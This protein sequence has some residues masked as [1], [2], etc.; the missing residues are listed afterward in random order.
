MDIPPDLQP[1]TPHLLTSAHSTFFFSLI[2]VLFWFRRDVDLDRLAE[3][4]MGSD[5]E[6]DRKKDGALP[7][8]SYTT[9]YGTTS[10]S[11]SGGDSATLPP[12]VL[13]PVYDAKARV[14]NRAVST[15][16]GRAHERC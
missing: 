7:D 6:Q 14:L 5:I 10:S 1:A 12:G 9:G 15:R 8:S 16:V 4:K 13:D 3:G 2:S 11:I